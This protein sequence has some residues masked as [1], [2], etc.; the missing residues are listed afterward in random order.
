MAK[1]TK[2]QRWGGTH[3]CL[4]VEAE[5]GIVNIYEGL[6]D[7][8]GREVTAVEILP[9]DHYAGEAKWKLVGTHNNRLIKLKKVI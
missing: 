4:H 1:A 8:K 7:S 6:H 3:K 2:L 5:G 9:S